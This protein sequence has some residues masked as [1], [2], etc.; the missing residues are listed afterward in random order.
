VLPARG[1]RAGGAS[2]RNGRRIW[3][4]RAALVLAVLALSGCETTA[5]ES[6]KIEAKDKREQAE[7]PTL[8][9]RGLSIA[10]ASTR[11]RVL[12]ATVVRDSESAA[13]A[14]TVSNSTSHT[15]SSV[16]IA[17]TVKNA[18]GQTLYENNAPGL[19]AGL[20]QIS[21]LP[22]HGSI[23]WVDDQVPPSG[24][25]ASVSALVGEAPA[26]E[27]RPAPRI[28]VEGLR[29]GEASPGETSGTVRNRSN[30]TQQHL[31]VYVLA[32]RA[33]GIVAAGRAVLAEVAPG[34]S[35][36]FQAFL[37]GAP[38]GATLQASAP[39]TTFG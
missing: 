25:P 21:S 26:G 1:L 34:A 37:V 35:V 12:A 10:H 17:I 28:E 4:V 19:E 16:P 24:E 29:L 13:A 22:P 11:L 20:T 33:G 27:P 2:G 23:T 36:Q 9:Q 38:H 39:A 5:E 15:L 30:V 7:H 6:A 3:T 18:H 31:I 8:A 32:R 14:V